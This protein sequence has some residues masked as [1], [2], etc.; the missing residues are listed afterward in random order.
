MPSEEL[1]KSRERVRNQGEVFTPANIVFDMIATIPDSKW[2]DPSFVV[3][4]P[5]C[6]NGNFLEGIIYKKLSC[7][8]PLVQA[9][10][11]TF[12]TDI[13]EENI[14]EARHRLLYIILSYGITAQDKRLTTCIIHHNTFQVNDFLKTTQAIQDKPFFINKTKKEAISIANSR[15][16]G[17]K[18]DI[19]FDFI[20]LLGDNSIERSYDDSQPSFLHLLGGAK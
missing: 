8:V 20:G 11:T 15:L 7:Q 10:N 18:I 16:K 1:I 5:T 3:L 14:D 13:C 2:A 12:G 19:D 6:G 4:E 9:L 17:V